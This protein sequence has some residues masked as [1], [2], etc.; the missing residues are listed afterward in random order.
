MGITTILQ[1]Q[2]MT[3]TGRGSEEKE[4]NRERRAGERLRMKEE[5]RGESKGGMRWVGGW[6]YLAPFSLSALLY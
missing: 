1:R 6:W 4:G 3:E 5:R 2:M